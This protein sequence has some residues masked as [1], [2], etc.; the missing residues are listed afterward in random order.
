VSALEASVDHYFLTFIQGSE[1]NHP[2]SMLTDI[3]T[4]TVE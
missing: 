3:N 4:N 2:Q 1:D